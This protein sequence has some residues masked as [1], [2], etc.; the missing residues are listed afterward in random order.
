[1][2]DRLCEIGRVR[3]EVFDADGATSRL[4][5]AVRLHDRARLNE[6]VRDRFL[7]VSGRSLGRLGKAEWIASALEVEWERFT[8]SVVRVVAL[9]EVVVVDHDIEQ[10]MKAS[11]RWAPGAPTR[12]HWAITDVWAAE[13]GAWRLV[14]RHPELKT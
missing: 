12:T 14:C 1:M 10:E 2:A 7:F 13:H 3:H 6:L 11:P 5:D 4:Q 9:D 8:V